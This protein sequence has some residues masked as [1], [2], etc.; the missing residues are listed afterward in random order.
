LRGQGTAAPCPQWLK[1]RPEIYNEAA[2]GKGF[3]G[4][5]IWRCR[6][7][8]RVRGRRIQDAE[9][10]QRKRVAEM[11]GLCSGIGQP[12]IFAHPYSGWKKCAVE[13]RNSLARLAAPKG[14]RRQRAAQ[15]HPRMPG[16]GALRAGDGQ[17]QW[18]ASTAPAPSPAAR[19]AAGGCMGSKQRKN[20][21][22]GVRWQLAAPPACAIVEPVLYISLIGARE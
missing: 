11:G 13:R 10:R 17:A 12:H 8:C 14:S 6:R 7:L 15:A 5:K 2:V 1:G 22:A 21:P 18:G 4:C 9:I 16:G 20:M 3:A 19:P